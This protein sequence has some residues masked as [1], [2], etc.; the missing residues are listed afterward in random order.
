MYATIRH[1]TPTPGTATAEK[2]DALGR[3]LHDGFV[4]MLQSVPGFHAYYALNVD[5]RELITI[6][7]FESRSGAEESNRRA[8][9]YLV[10]NPAP[11]DAGRP[12]VMQ[13]EVLT[14]AEAAREVGAR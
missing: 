13:G 2:M 11:I 7:V 12:E 1:Y 10:S 8:A 5:D 4:P 14:S 3:Q 9:E 6:S